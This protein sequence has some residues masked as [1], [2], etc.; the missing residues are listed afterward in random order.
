LFDTSRYRKH[1]LLRMK[2]ED[3]RV[4]AIAR[5]DGADVLQQGRM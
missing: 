1:G 5:R 4:D 3:A 2:G